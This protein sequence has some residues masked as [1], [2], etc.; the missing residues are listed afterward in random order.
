MKNYQ[1]MS[2][3]SVSATAGRRMPRFALAGDWKK[4]KLELKGVGKI[5]ADLFNLVVALHI[6]PVDG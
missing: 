1:V 3:R 4:I 6:L 2:Q 5:L